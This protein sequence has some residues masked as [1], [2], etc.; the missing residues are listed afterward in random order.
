MRSWVRYLWKAFNARPFGVP[1]PPFWF[2]GAGLRIAR[3]SFSIPPSG[4]DRRRRATAACVGFVAGNARFRNAIDAPLISLPL[5]DQHALLL[6]RLDDASKARQAKLEE[7]CRQLQKRARERQ[8]RQRAYP[9]RLAARRAASAPAGGALRRGFRRQRSR[10]RQTASVSPIRSRSST[11]RLAQ[12][13]LDDD[14]RDALE[15]QE[16]GPRRSGWPCRARRVGAC[17]CWTPSSS[18]SASRSRSSGSRRC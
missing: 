5:P 6:D 3:A 11:E 16:Q 8:C 1:I 2:V 13:D 12:P 4:D 9:R 14:L 10:G 15:D 17:R 18:A 7:Q